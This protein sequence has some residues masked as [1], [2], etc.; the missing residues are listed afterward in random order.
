M[1][2]TGLLRNRHVVFASNPSKTLPKLLLCIFTVN[3]GGSKK[4]VVFW[5]LSSPIR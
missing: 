4:G 5:L 1:A 2:L 3:L